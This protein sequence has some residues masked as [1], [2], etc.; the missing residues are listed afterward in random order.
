MG[1]AFGPSLPLEVPTRY[2]NSGA[3]A[4]RLYSGE[5]KGVW[6][7]KIA[8]LWFLSIVWKLGSL[9]HCSMAIIMASFRRC[10]AGSKLHTDGDEFEG[11]DIAL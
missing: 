3:Y 2:A 5:L 10:T 7:G 1:S 9:L 8:L 6:K 11:L 4:L